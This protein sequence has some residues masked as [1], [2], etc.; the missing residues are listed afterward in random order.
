MLRTGERGLSE[1]LFGPDGF[2]CVYVWTNQMTPS[3]WLHRIFHCL[4]V[5]G[6]SSGVAG[7]GLLELCS[8]IRLSLPLLREEERRALARGFTI[9]RFIYFTIT[10]VDI[11][12]LFYYL[13]VWVLVEQRKGEHDDDGGAHSSLRRLLSSSAPP[14]SSSVRIPTYNYITGRCDWIRGVSA[15]R[16]LLTVAKRRKPTAG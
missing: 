6:G 2:M 13:S 3:V 4:C 1:N 9:V 8:K 11:L 5:Y 14:P 15:P 12:S 16:C 10:A 7:C